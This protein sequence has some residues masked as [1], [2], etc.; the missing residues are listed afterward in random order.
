VE[1]AENE[2]T[3][4]RMQSALA[5]WHAPD[6]AE[7]IAGSIL[8]ACALAGISETAAPDTGSRRS[9]PGAPRQFSAA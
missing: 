7:K 1:L 8:N 9:S 3:R 2:T 5:Q 6:A 4:S